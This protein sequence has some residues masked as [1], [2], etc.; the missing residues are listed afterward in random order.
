MLDSGLSQ[1]RDKFGA[2]SE[3]CL[4]GGCAEIVGWGN[5]KDF[6]EHGDEG[7][8]GAVPGVEGGVGDLGAFGEEAHSVHEAELLTPLAK[9]CPGF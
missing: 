1:N 7:A 6:A 4:F 8:G 2:T 5:S 3:S 9:G